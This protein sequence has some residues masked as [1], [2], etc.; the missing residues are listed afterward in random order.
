VGERLE[1]AGAI[2][3]GLLFRLAARLTGSG[4]SIKPGEYSISPGKNVMEILGQLKEGG[5][6]LRLVTIPEGLTMKQIA[7]LLEKKGVVSARDFLDAAGKATL[8][9]GGSVPASLE[10]YLLPE[11]YDIPESYSAGDVL[12]TLAGDFNRKAVPLYRQ[13]APSLPVK[14]TLHQVVVLASMVEREAK[15]PG[16]RPVI[17]AV[18]YNRL[19]KGMLLQ[20]D[21]TVQYALGEQKEYLTL[22]DLK[23]D[24][25]YNTYAHKGLPPGP[26]ANP[27]LDSI[28][29]TLQP[30]KVDYLYYVRNDV[31]NDG[32]HVF[33][34][35]YAGHRDAIRKYQR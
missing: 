7:A 14:M 11:T 27:G 3:S 12:K 20:C 10:G 15:V 6:R 24:S 22:E 31:K 35:S 34:S 32:S 30:E 8:S 4:S 33:S 1:R 17:A 18:Y 21:A 5:G 13:N 28:R 25:P 19:K 29:A 26:I 23:I 16:E 9:I 2:K